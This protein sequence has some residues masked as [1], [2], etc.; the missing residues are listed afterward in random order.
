MVGLEECARVGD[1]FTIG[2]PVKRFDTGNP[3]A[4][5]RRVPRDMLDQLVFGLCR[6][7]HKDC[8]CIGN[9]LHYVVEEVMVLARVT[10]ANAVGLVVDMLRGIVRVNQKLISLG[11]IEMKD[12]GFEMIDPNDRVIMA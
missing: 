11:D 1:E 12:A 6:P 10:A 2:K 7:G 4:H 9:G 8:A 3:C 5:Q